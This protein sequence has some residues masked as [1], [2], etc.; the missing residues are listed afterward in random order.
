MHDAG[1][2]FGGGV[3]GQVDRREAVVA[4][5]DMRQRMAEMDA[6]ERFALRRRDHAAL[7]AVARQALL[8]QRC[9][10]QQLP[11]LGV[12]QRV[13]ERRVQVERLVGGDGPRGGGPDHREGLADDLGQ[14]EGRGQLVGLGAEEA[15]VD[16]LRL[17]VGVL[18][19]EL[20]QRRAAVEAPVHGLEAAVDEAALDHA[21]EGAHL[22]GLVGEVHRA[23]R[24]LPV[25]EH[26][27]ALA[28][29]HLLRDLL[30]GVGAALGLHLVAR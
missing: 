19:L 14:A 15:D 24:V 23:V 30:G 22:A 12:H 13:L 10:Q 9:G 2:V 20:G 25:A 21:L 3:V 11:A 4:C 1:A 5:V 6:G 17:L 29:G 18:D 27:Q 26:A 7:Q 16:R 8:D 28:V